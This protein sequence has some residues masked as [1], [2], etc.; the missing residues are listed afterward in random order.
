MRGVAGYERIAIP[1]PGGA[2]PGFRLQAKGKERSTL[3]FTGGYEPFVEEIYN[4]LLPFTDPG[5]RW[6][7]STDPARWR[8]AAGHL[9][10]SCVDPRG[11]VRATHQADPASAS[12]HSPAPAA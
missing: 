3:V 11:G 6:S 4:F 2:L 10:G 5:I 8:A 9:Y 1:Y 7:P 12:T